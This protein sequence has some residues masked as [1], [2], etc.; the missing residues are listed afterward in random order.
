M[1]AASTIRY[2]LL[3]VNAAE[4]LGEARRRAGLTQHEL[5]ARAGLPQSA[6]SAYERGRKQPTM[7]VLARLVAAAG[8]TLDL[9]LVP[10]AAPPAPF[11][12]PVG[13]RLQRNR[14][15]VRALLSEAGFGRPEVFGSVARGEDR[16][17]SD[18]DVL[19]DLPAG[20]GLFALAGAKRQASELAGV[21]VDLVPR[22][23]LR[24]EI[25]ARIVDD[26]APL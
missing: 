15:G 23:G 21:P 24:P 4:V 20:I 26:L 19:V 13:R 2:M 14:D 1:K 6:V 7:P 12:G 22:S 3:R 18:V 25:A 17:D 11:V 5:G 8:F 10:A 9:Q 16:P